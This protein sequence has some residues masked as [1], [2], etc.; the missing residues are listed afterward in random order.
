MWSKAG[1]L[2]A[3]YLGAYSYRRATSPH[4]DALAK[5][6]IVFEQAMSDETS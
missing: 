2:R 5:R 6:S 3:D 1:T 4:L